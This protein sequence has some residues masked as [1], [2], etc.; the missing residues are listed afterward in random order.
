M[1][2]PSDPDSGAPPPGGS[3]GTPSYGSE[4][5]SGGTP[6]YG[7]PPPPKGRP[8]AYTIGALGVLAAI[9]FG[10]YS[11]GT[12]TGGPPTLPVTA[13]TSPALST[14]T[15]AYPPVTDEPV[16]PPGTTTALPPITAGPPKQVD[17]GSGGAATNGGSGDLG[18]VVGG[19]L[20]TAVALAALVRERRRAP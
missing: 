20:V 10:F 19:V 15:A 16:E 13:P 11:C 1:T 4:P 7:G 9:L 2:Y 14:N 12:G 6:T 3:G 8:V 5:G 18:L 17:A